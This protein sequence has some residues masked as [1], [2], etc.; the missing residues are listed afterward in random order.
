MLGV[1]T[2]KGRGRAQEAVKSKKPAGDAQERIVRGLG[3][4]ARANVK[5]TKAM[6]PPNVAQPSTQ[7]SDMQSEN[8][9]GS[10]TAVPP[11]PPP[12]APETDDDEE[13][14][15][16]AKK[17]KVLRNPREPTEAEIAEHK[18]A[19]HTPYRSWCEGCV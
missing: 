11:P 6:A 12:F 14:T 15:G 13:P 17:L 7:N 3:A 4:G 8:G 9:E 1:H 19:F 16:E 10:G 5:V 2:R 18:T